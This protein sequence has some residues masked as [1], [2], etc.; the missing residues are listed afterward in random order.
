[1][2]LNKTSVKQTQVLVSVV[3][4]GIRYV[5]MFAGFTTADGK[6]KIFQSDFDA[7]LRSLRIGPHSAI[8]IG[9]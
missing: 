1:M 8:F 6:T 5:K 3:H 9:G 2:K 4:R 7:W